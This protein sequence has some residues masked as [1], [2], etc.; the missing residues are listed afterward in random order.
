MVQNKHI[1]DVPKVDDVVDQQRNV[2][3]IV[4]DHRIADHIEDITMCRVHVN[5]TVVERPIVHHATDDFI[6]DDDAQLSP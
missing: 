3:K 4:V 5:P 1:W 2:S 6:D